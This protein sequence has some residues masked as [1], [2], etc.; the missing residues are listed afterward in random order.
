MSWDFSELNPFSC[1]APPPSKVN[2]ASE[3]LSKTGFDVKRRAIQLDATAAIN[4][5]EHPMISTDPPYYDNIGYADLS[6]FST[7]GCG[8]R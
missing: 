1:L 2:T 8:A 4:G 7:S 5:V 6:D 3:V